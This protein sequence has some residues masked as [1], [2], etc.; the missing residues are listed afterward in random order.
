MSLSLI[1]LTIAVTAVHAVETINLS[2]RGLPFAG[3]GAQSTAGS[4]R[5]LIDYQEPQRSQV[6]DFL[7][8]PSFGTA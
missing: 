4:A 1:L 5:L 2:A 6:L 3:V 7:F 8:K